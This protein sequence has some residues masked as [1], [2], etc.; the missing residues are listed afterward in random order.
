MKVNRNLWLRIKKIFTVLKMF[1]IIKTLMVMDLTQV[2]I[3]ISRTGELPLMI[4][5]QDHTVVILEEQ[6]VQQYM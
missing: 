5:I 2:L 4:L 6:M 3:G 1:Q